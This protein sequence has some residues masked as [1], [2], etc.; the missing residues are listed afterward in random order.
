MQ[1]WK[2]YKH[3]ED[4][5]EVYT[6]KVF[7]LESCDRE[8][9]TKCEDASRVVKE[10]GASKYDYILVLQGDYGYG[11]GWEDLSAYDGPN[12]WKDSRAGKREYLDNDQSVRGLRVIARRELV[13]A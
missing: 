12:R 11:H 9:V 10:R 7:Y 3:N 1:G 4:G 6:D 5:A 13:Q 2:I 8:Y